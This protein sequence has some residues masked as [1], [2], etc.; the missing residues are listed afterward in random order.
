[1]YR[2][3]DD[4]TTVY[5]ANRSLEPAGYRGN[6]GLPTLTVNQS[7]LVRIVGEVQ[8][9]QHAQACR[10]WLVM[11]CVTWI[12]DGTLKG[13][14]LVR[15]EQPALTLGKAQC[16]SKWVDVGRLSRNTYGRNGAFK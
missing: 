11:E 14:D 5:S 13:S 12:A 15:I 3:F 7:T 2:G 6:F 1:M 16:R 4:D 10:G 8:H 9:A